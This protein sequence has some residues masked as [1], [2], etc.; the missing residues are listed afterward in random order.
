MATNV[1]TTSTAQ[2]VVD[3]GQA[4][5]PLRVYDNAWERTQKRVA[6]VVK[7]NGYL[8]LSLTRIATYTAI[9][10][11]FGSMAK[12]L[13]DNIE[14][15]LRLAEVST[16]VDSKNEQQA[17]SFEEIKGQ[18]LHL[19]PY[20]GSVIDMTKGLYEIMSA[21]V[22]DP[23]AAM[24]ILT[25][26]AKYA[27]AGVTDLKTAA[28]SLTSIIKAYALTADDA[29][30]MSDYLFASVMEGKYHAEDLNEA[31]GRILPTAAG[32][33]I[34]MDEVGAAMAVLS[35]RG[36]DAGESATALNRLMIS[37]MKPL[38]KNQK[39]MHDL[40]LEYGMTAFHSGGL[41]GALEKLTRA[42]ATHNNLLPELF[43][44]E[45][46]L[47]AAFIL[48]GK[49]AEEY[50]K[51]LE[52]VR[53]MAQGVGEV[54]V[55]H[56]KIIKTVAE[57]WKAMIVTIQQGVAQIYTTMNALSVLIKVLGVLFGFV[58]RNHLWLMTL[59]GAFKILIPIVGGLT[60]KLLTYMG[61]LAGLND[62]QG[63]YVRMHWYKSKA[64]QAEITSTTIL[65][66]RYQLL[67]HWI[68]ALSIGLI[69]GVAAYVILREAL[70]AIH[71]Y[72][73]KVIA[74]IIEKSI[75]IKDLRDKL[76][77]YAQV[78]KEASGETA[79]FVKAVDQLALAEATGRLMQLNSQRKI[80][81]TLF[82][83][84]APLQNRTIENDVQLLKDVKG[85]AKALMNENDLTEKQISMIRAYA[86]ESGLWAKAVAFVTKNIEKNVQTG[87]YMEEVYR[88]MRASLA[89]M[90]EA[91]GLL[92]MS[93]VQIAT[94]NSRESM[95]KYSAAIDYVLSVLKGDKTSYAFLILQTWM[96]KSG[97]TA[98]DLVTDLTDLRK[99]LDE[100]FKMKPN[101]DFKAMLEEATNAVMRQLEGLILT[102]TQAK[103]KADALWAG[104]Q[105]AAKEGLNIKD[106]ADL[107]RSQIEQLV[108][109][110][111]KVPADMKGFIL[112]LQA[113]LSKT[114]MFAKLQKSAESAA[115]S[116]KDAFSRLVDDITQM[117]N[118][119][120]NEQYKDI[121][122][123]TK[124]ENDILKRK[125]ADWYEAQKKFYGLT[126]SLALD[127]VMFIAGMKKKEEQANLISIERWMKS[128]SE[129]QQEMIRSTEDN[130]S[131]RLLVTKKMYLGMQQ[132]LIT[133][134]YIFFPGMVAYMSKIWDDA[135]L[136]F[137]ESVKKTQ[138]PLEEMISRVE[139]FGSMFS[140]L[141]THLK[142]FFSVFNSDGGKVLQIL[143]TM[144][145]AVSAVSAGLRSLAEIEKQAAKEGNNF[146]NKLSRAATVADLVI[147]AVTT[148]ISVFQTLFS[149]TEAEKL[150]KA[151]RKAKQELQ[152]FGEIS[153][154]VA[155]DFAKLSE[156]MGK[157][158]ATMM[159]L[160]EIMNDTGINTN[161][162]NS[163]MAEMI[164]MVQT[165]SD[166]SWM[167]NTKEML[168]IQDSLAS[169]FTKMIEYLRKI[170][171]EGSAAMTAL[172]IKARELGI[173]I[174][175]I[176]DYVYEWLSRGAAGIS[177]MIDA[178]GGLTPAMQSHMNALVDIDNE[179]QQIQK[180]QEMWRSALEAA[181]EGSAAWKRAKEALAELSE[182][183]D[184]LNI[185]LQLHKKALG[186]IAETVKPELDRVASYLLSVFNAAISQGKTLMEALD[187]I[188]E[189]LS[190]LAAKY[191]ILGLEGS[192]AIK[193]LLHIEAVRKKNTELFEAI[194]GLNEVIQ[195]LGNTGFLTA[196]DFSAMQISIGDYF[197]RLQKAGLSSKEALA[198]I[199]PILANLEYYAKKYGFTLDDATLALIK[200]AKEAGVYDEKQ[201]TLMET[202][203][204]G[205]SDIVTALGDIIKLLGGENGV[206]DSMDDFA[207]RTR[208]AW[209]DFDRGIGKAIEDSKTLRGILDDYYDREK[210]GGGAK[211]GAQAG[212][213]YVSGTKTIRVHKGE[214]I[215]PANISES[216]RTFFGGTPPT[217]T[218]RGSAEVAE[219]ALSID[220]VAFYKA[221]APIFKKATAK[222][223]DMEMQ[224]GGVF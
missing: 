51:M 4:V 100:A 197:D 16:L 52:K 209:K 25:Q 70:R 54:E 111:N 1:Q 195:A 150:E 115:E 11:F 178:V 32:M 10:T 126:K 50:A 168:D 104:W 153:D 62:L 164:N 77:M 58:V 84:L 65:V 172:I 199:S 107:F 103:V 92:D 113:A 143:D 139:V 136:G 208:G 200:Q 120:N 193:Q 191:R 147:V 53:G 217:I 26:S 119:I 207:K 215:L 184:E 96:T 167:G 72:L 106:F 156:K 7:Q 95:E 169:S 210:G 21:G 181:D 216:L 127:Y 105:Y 78:V 36:L 155:Q 182:K 144:S 213:Q 189:P 142:E 123:E 141:T 160:D 79:N 80:E 34:G 146:L 67:V 14:L 46:G 201:K 134:G 45:R 9:F 212:M 13:K 57:E 158:V 82:E 108:A 121:V 152:R 17:K 122:S 133:F 109:N 43:T 162:F 202:L 154:G 71:N 194:S 124:K 37:F 41:L 125:L 61:A 128:Y 91:L 18:L 85:L 15:Q 175:E 129:A 186:D 63:E 157:S 48:T 24:K 55:A 87:T 118:E 223:G 89:G 165:L 214:S 66:N 102:T 98:G 88:K 59:I 190:K 131:Q 192:D 94:D 39:L 20:L 27:K 90:S 110:L 35:Q 204:K 224:G 145:K 137:I 163:Y 161:N 159:M 179:M 76:S 60:T 31:L 173:H 177:K 148:L 74:K 187:L 56:Q 116:M 19:S 185:D 12:L 3:V 73:D 132:F 6:E 28:A 64:L 22:T 211:G 2:L 170:G 99:A 196:E 149:E 135:W 205:F 42:A 166:L 38:S 69:A 176:D 83:R 114:D 130:A 171:E 86:K 221:I 81:N 47:R 198:V 203:E 140:T 183:W 8:S 40:G 33:G 180:D 97:R 220:G 218:G 101:V 93:P 44:R 219:V 112:S 117:Q 68:R 49:G 29:R 174:K 5:G 151:I 75:R 138:T 206:S 222:Y 188:A 30:E 23:V